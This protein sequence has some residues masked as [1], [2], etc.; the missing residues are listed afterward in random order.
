MNGNENVH[1]FKVGIVQVKTESYAPVGDT[2]RNISKSAAADLVAVRSNGLL[3]SSEKCALAHQGPCA[4]EQPKECSARPVFVLGCPRSGTTLLYHMI[5]SSGDFAGYPFESDTFRILGPK[6][7]G[8]NLPRN[9]RR[10]LEFWLQSQNGAE[11][12]LSRGDVEERIERECRNIGDFLRIVM[13]AMCRKQGV[14]RWAEKTPDH[15][16]SIAKIKRFLPDAL[17]VHIIRD[18]R[19]AAISLANWGRIQPYFH[20]AGSKLLSFGA[21]WKWLVGK[22]RSAGRRIGAD[23]YELH[24]ENLVEKPR[25]T[26]AQLGGFIGHN[27]D[28]DRISQVA[29][30]SVSAPNTSFQNLA[31]PRGGNAVGRWKKQ[32]SPAELAAFEALVGDCLQATGYTLATPLAE[33]RKALSTAGL[34]AFY[35]SQLELKYQLKSQT[36]LRR[37]AGWRS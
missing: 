3:I 8:L 21:Y 10:L 11:S 18:G 12:G 22:G 31:S 30:G 35:R 5:L 34:S 6:F 36:P 4:D 20:Q 13:E 29:V 1:L 14:R 23:Y 32:Y 16:L 2:T 27:L 9:R 28:Y 33:R 26:L 24:Y 19:D 25:D 37:L 15:I 17:I 7:P